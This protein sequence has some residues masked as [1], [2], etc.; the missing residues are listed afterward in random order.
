M[1]F[2]VCYI[3]TSN[4][5]RSVCT[6]QV[7][8]IPKFWCCTQYLFWR[9]THEYTTRLIIYVCSN[10]STSCDHGDIRKFLFSLYLQFRNNTEFF[11]T[12][13]SF[14][15]Q[16]FIKFNP[17]IITAFEF[18]DKRM[19]VTHLNPGHQ[20]TFINPF[21]S[22]YLYLVTNFYL[23]SS[24]GSKNLSRIHPITKYFT[25]NYL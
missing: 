20:N 16:F 5:K 22:S 25:F 6:C 8:N 1:P 2:S 21:T 4:C 10:R 23:L 3:F 9:S 14:Y 19:F 18:N 7:N 13:H 17:N 15:F 24:Q 11:T 12:T